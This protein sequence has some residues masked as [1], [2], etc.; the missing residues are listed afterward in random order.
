VPFSL[1]I[2]KSLK[3]V[4]WAWGVFYALSGGLLLVWLWPLLWLRTQSG[5]T[6]FFGMMFLAPL[7]AG[8]CLLYGRLL[9]RLAWRAS[10]EFPQEEE[11]EE[12]DSDK[13]PKRPKRKKKKPRPAESSG[14]LQTTR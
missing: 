5:W 4:N 6:Q 1:P 2:L 3:T 10:L 13:K 12:K 8:W 9:G 14:E 7:I 11:P